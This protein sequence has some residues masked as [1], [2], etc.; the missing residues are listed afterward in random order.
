[1]VAGGNFATV[2]PTGNNNLDTQGNS[3]AGATISEA[4][5]T[6]QA[7]TGA[8]EDYSFVKVSKPGSYAPPPCVV[9][10]SPKYKFV[11]APTNVE[12][13]QWFCFVTKGRA[14]TTF[15]IKQD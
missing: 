1:M 10:T 12:E 7:E 8:Y 2:V 3:G 5:N 4:R 15:C 14:Q 9:S 11:V 13:L 6:A